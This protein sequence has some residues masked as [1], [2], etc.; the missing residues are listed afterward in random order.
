MVN[1]QEYIHKFEE[2]PYLRYVRVGLLWAAL[3]VLWVGY[4]W[5]CFRNM[6][7]LEAMDAAQVARN[8]SEGRGFTTQFVRPLSIYVVKQ[9]N[10][11]KYG[12][13][14]PEAD[15][16]RLRGDHPDLS[17][18]PLYPALLAGWMKV[19][20]KLFPTDPTH[21]VWLRDGK[22]SR[23]PDDFFIGLLNQLLFFGVLA[24]TFFLSRRL[25][26][27]FTAWL[28]TALLLGCEVMWRFSISGLATMLL[29]AIFLGLVWLLVS[30]ESEAREPKHGT[31]RL[32]FLA[33]GIGVL[34]GLGALTRYSF[35]WIIV[36]VVVF[37][38]LFMPQR[39]GLLS[40]AAV[41]AFLAVLL[42][43]LARNHSVCGSL[44]GLATFAPLEATYIFPSY[45]LERSLT[46]DFSVV[47][48][49]PFVHKLFSGLRQLMQDDF[50][51]LGGS[52][53]TPFFL[54][55]LLL[56]FRNPALRRL[57]YF[58]VGTL[59]VF[60]IAQSLTRTQASEDIK[61]VNGENLI[62]LI[63]PLVLMYGVS[64]FLTLLEQINFIDPLLRYLAIAAFALIMCIPMISVFLPPRV[65]SLAYPPYYPPAIRQT[66][67]FMKENEL[68]MSDIPWAVAWY[69]NRQCIWLT[70]NA[71]NEFF[72][73][74]D[75]LK[76]IRGLYLTPLTMD[77]RFLSEWVRAGEH[78]WGS[79]VLES[80]TRGE[81]PPSFPL[82]KAPNGY[83]P[84]QLFLTDWERWRVTPEGGA[85]SPTAAK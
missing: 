29:L 16:P 8:L 13:G 7:T 63:F 15:Y 61:D 58:A 33:A 65:R 69:G 84:E 64:M 71:Q 12:L 46:P 6:N 62:I 55:G 66:A 74:N 59:V 78:S 75:I 28:T 81:I 34:A 70:L 14:R 47:H 20:P 4:N 21:R 31:T 85:T 67:A 40:L 32:L 25:F 36:P 76:P 5:F 42:P 49:K 2:G 79:F 9:R 39:R 22:T 60:M 80:M 56:A 26:D 24:L 53:A 77:S 44:F 82:R 10:E 51:R 27:G 73:V 72:A 37:I 43:W 50:L 45:K 52:W 17:N 83:L 38:V 54:V 18:P 19:Y 41:V 35:G 57:R 23:H 68:M 30:L 1:L 48:L 3:V 11:Q